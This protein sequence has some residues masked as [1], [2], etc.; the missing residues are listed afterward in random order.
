[1][2]ELGGESRAAHVSSSGESQGP[3]KNEMNLRKSLRCSLPSFHREGVGT[4]HVKKNQLDSKPQ[5][6]MDWG[7]F[8]CGLH[9][10]TPPPGRGPL[11][12]PGHAEAAEQWSGEGLSRRLQACPLC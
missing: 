10:T 6:R 3:P 8:P 12:K 9:P 1:M 4:V 2:E 11:W 7:Q 5:H